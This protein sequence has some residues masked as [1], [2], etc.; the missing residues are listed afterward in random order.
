M[1]L[2]SPHNITVVIRM[3]YEIV[4]D[5]KLGKPIYAVR[6]TMTGEKHGWTTK[7]KAEAQMRLL[8]GIEGGMKPRKK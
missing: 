2:R 7:E 5:Y 1:A 8:Y 3:P 4:K 6:N